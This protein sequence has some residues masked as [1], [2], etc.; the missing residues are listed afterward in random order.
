[1]NPS[2]AVAGA[3]YHNEPDFENPILTFFPANVLISKRR[4]TKVL[5]LPGS[6]SCIIFGKWHPDGILSGAEN[7][8][9]PLKKNRH[10]ERSAPMPALRKT[11]FPIP[12]P[13]SHSGHHY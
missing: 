8:A 4:G 9:T 7:A 11:G 3:V 5:L 12:K 13:V 6:D 1:M 2:S 10:H